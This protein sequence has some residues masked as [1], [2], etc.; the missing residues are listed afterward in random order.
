MKS[1]PYGWEAWDSPERRFVRE[2]WAGLKLE[3][4][5]LYAKAVWLL[6]PDD[7]GRIEHKVL[8]WRE[9]ES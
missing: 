4:E 2:T 6:G 3:D 1:G 7:L 8:D 9:R 5:V